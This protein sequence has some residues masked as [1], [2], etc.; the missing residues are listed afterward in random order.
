MTECFH[1]SRILL[2]EMSL[3]YGEKG[4]VS[5]S[6]DREDEGLACENSQVTHHLARV[7]DKQQGL[8]LAVN[9]TLVNVE[10]T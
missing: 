7:G 5:V 10:R 2:V 6:S 1:G 3:G 8:L 4:A 9:H